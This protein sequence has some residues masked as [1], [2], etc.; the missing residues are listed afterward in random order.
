MFQEKKSELVK[1]FATKPGDTGSPEVQIALQSERINDLTEHFKVHKHD[2]HGRRGLM[3]L[4]SQRRGLLNY[5]KGKD[6]ERYKKLIDQL[7][8][9][10]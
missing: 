9:R 10:K 2:H 7:G 3:K 8:L 4:V 6:L 5:L 1:K